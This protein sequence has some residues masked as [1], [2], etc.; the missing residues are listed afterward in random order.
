MACGRL[1]LRAAEVLSNYE[2]PEDPAWFRRHRLAFV[3]A[4]GYLMLGP[5]PHGR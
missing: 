1:F 3:Y 4:A 2:F 5:E